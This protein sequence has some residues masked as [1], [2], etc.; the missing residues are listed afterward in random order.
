MLVTTSITLGV[1]TNCSS[2]KTPTRIKQQLMIQEI[3]QGLTHIK[4]ALSQA[5]K[6]IG[7]NILVEEANKII[8]ISNNRLQLLAKNSRLRQVVSINLTQLMNAHRLVFSSSPQRGFLAKTI[9]A[10]AKEAGQRAKYKCKFREQLRP[11]SKRLEFWPSLRHIRTQRIQLLT[12]HCDKLCRTKRSLTSILIIAGNNN[13]RVEPLVT[14]SRQKMI[15][16][17]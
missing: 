13:V 16:L 10:K 12:N 17:V 7:T 3:L 8:T 2:L 6:N 11:R 5:V 4:L 14:V 1:T 9:L 15:V